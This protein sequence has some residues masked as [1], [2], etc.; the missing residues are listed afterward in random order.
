M[1]SPLIFKLDGRALRVEKKSFYQNKFKDDTAYVLS[2]YNP[3]VYPYYGKI[4][5]KS[6]I[7][8]PGI[9][10]LD[11]KVYVQ[12]PINSDE[13][14]LYD[15]RNIIKL[16]PE[17]IFKDL[18]RSECLEFDNI[19]LFGEDDIFTPVITAKDDIALAGMKFAISK[20]RINFNNYGHKFTDSATKNNGR[21]AL[22]HGTTLKMEMLSRYANVF[23]LGV[24]LVFYDKQDCPNPMD[25]EYKKAYVI[26]DSEPTDLNEKEFVEISIDKNISNTSVEDNIDI[27]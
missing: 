14:K 1:L 26:F 7:T 20:K 6:E 19:V 22:T 24:G 27:Y 11:N 18:D 9:Y 2:K 23:D 4:K 13:R 12:R 8:G 10:I 15:R 16:T 5:D 25:K 3:Y 17:S 21:R